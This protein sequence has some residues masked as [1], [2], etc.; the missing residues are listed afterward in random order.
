MSSRV[1]AI[2]EYVKKTINGFV[3]ALTAAVTKRS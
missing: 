2:N 3:A 1:D